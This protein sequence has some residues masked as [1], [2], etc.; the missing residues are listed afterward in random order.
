[1]R[2]YTL[3]PLASIVLAAAGLLSAGAASAASPGGTVSAVVHA[4]GHPDTCAC[5]SPTGVTSPNGPVWAYDNI[6]RQFTAVPGSGDH[7][8]VTITD[9]GS[10]AAFADPISGLPFTA[11]GSIRGTYTLDVQ[12][13]LPP[14]A[15]ALPPTDDG[16][17]STPAMIMQLFQG[18]V[19][20]IVGGDY[21][22]TYRAGGCT[23]VQDTSGVTGDIC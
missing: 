20:S 12:S 15:S 5:A 19:T 21:T 17:V 22:Y 13:T 18:G 6:A 23:M 2:K 7:Y 16:D 9:N 3:I 11:H 10:F 4:S 14:L 8:T 1:M